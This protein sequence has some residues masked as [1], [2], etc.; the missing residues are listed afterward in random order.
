[1]E[2]GQL[3]TLAIRGWRT[4]VREYRL[5]RGW[6]A[7]QDDAVEYMTDNAPDAP[8]WLV[9]EVASSPMD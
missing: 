6:N 7:W 1:M 4:A 2:A 9:G 5:D 3:R 8:A